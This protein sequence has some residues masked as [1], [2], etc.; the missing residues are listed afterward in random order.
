MPSSSFLRFCCAALV[1]AAPAIG[2]SATP[3]QQALD[4]AIAR[5]DS[6]FSFAPYG[7]LI[8]QND[9]SLVISASGFSI[10]G[11][12]T[13]LSFYPGFGVLFDGSADVALKNVTI[14]YSPS[15]F[16]QG[17]VVAVN[18]SASP[19]TVDVKLD[20]GF[21][22]PD[23]GFF[24]TVETKLQFYSGATPA[25]LRIPGQSGSCIVDVVG[26]VAPGVWRVA[27]AS[28]FRCV[29]PP[30]ANLLASISPRVNAFG[31]QIPD[32]YIGGAYWVFNSSRVRSDDV[33]ILGSGN[34]AVTEWG[35]EG[36]HVYTNLVLDRDG[37]RNG[38]MSSNTDGFHSF[39]TGVGPTL[40]NATLRFM[41][42]D[43]A[44]FHDRVAL[45]LSASPAAPG[46]TLALL[47]D[48]GD[49]PTPAHDPQNPARAFGDVRAGDTL[50]VSNPAGVPRAGGGGTPTVVSMVWDDNA[51]TLAAAKAAIVSRG[52]VAVNPLG[53][54]VW[55]VTWSTP[56][57]AEAP[58][59]GDV[60]QFDRRATAGAS[61]RDCTFS[62]AYDSCFR[63]QASNALISGNTWERI[64]GGV[65]VVYDPSWLEGSSDIA[66][67]ALLSNTFHAIGDPPATSIKQILTV[68]AVVQNFTQSDNQVLAT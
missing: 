4:A 56:A 32:G 8:V 61:V 22:T 13:T 49:M 66:N 48:V 51:T 65:S 2:A 40:V 68:D 19:P 45:V 24:T 17:S 52:G 59:P 57:G 27:Q 14:V 34:F 63:L 67:V 20:D 10:D 11:A 60:V 12:G 16:T 53:I 44:N 30:L 36:G 6:S 62:D 41:G 35:G 42:D 50:R 28:G 1:C 29:F 3:L 37:A 21:P 9:S 26:L 7:P 58:Q 31:Y 46:T 25:R 54:G 47:I 64:P 18:E 33:T 43:V 23:A 55:S 15:C 5:G 38:L 39:S